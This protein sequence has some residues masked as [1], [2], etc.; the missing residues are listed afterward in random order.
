MGWDGAGLVQMWWGRARVTAVTILLVF[1]E[2][3]PPFA[4]DRSKKYIKTTKNYMKIDAIDPQAAADN[5]PP[6]P[7]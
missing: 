1:F 7:R 5:A 2:V 4:I 6:T 3:L